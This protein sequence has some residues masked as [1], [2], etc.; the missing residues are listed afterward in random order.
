MAPL[1]R[2]PLKAKPGQPLG[3]D[4]S[5]TRTQRSREPRPS[6]GEPSP[7]RCRD[8]QMHAAPLHDGAQLL[9]ISAT[10]IEHQRQHVIARAGADSARISLESAGVTTGQRRAMYRPRVRPAESHPWKRDGN[11][12]VQSGE[13]ACL[14]NLPK[15]VRFRRFGGWVK[16]RETAW[17][18]LSRRRSRVRVPSLP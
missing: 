9:P 10:T 3:S 7:V 4:R 5:S 2:G 15:T 14:R 6:S 16:P 8:E 11:K 12:P 13:N 18:D 17:S 1:R